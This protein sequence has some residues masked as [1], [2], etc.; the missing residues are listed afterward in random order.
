MLDVEGLSRWQA[1][2]PNL[3]ELWIISPAFRDD[4]QPHLRASIAD[5]LKRGVR[6]LYFLGKA[7]LEEGKPFWLFLRRLAAE[8]RKSSA[9]VEKQIQAIP[10]DETE[11]R[12]ITSDLFL[13][14]P[15]DPV[16]RAG[17]VGLRYDQANRFAFRMSDWD[18]E[19][20]VGSISPLV[21]KKLGKE[22]L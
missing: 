4:K 1:N 8:L 18:V 3:K 5:N 6:F 9:Q 19:V 10:L 14:N 13:A 15:T 16:T 7:D 22:R 11:R 17:F 2:F 21:V 20:T 12:W